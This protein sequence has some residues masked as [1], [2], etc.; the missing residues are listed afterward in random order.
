MIVGLLL[1]FLLGL[2]FGSFF[3]L[4]ADRSITNESIVKGH[5]HCDF[6][7]TELRPK[8]LIPVF[9]YVLSGGKCRYCSHQLSFWYPLSE[10]VTG[11][12]FS[13]AYIWFVLEGK[14]IIF[15]FVIFSF[16]AILFITDAKYQ[17]IPDQ[18]VYKAIAFAFIWL[19]AETFMRNYQ[20]MQT[21]GLTLDI[22]AL[23]GK[24]LAV[25]TYPLVSAA[26]IALFFWFLVWITK[27]RGMGGGDITLGLLLGL[28]TGF[29]YNVLA[30][31]LAMIFGALYSIPL[32]LVRKKGMKDAVAFGPFLIIGSIT[33]IFFGS[34]LITAYIA[35]LL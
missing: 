15:A 13:V 35:H 3:K 31:F 10:L 24:S 2:F 14:S 20:V 1:F 22:V 25:L 12:L 27:E 29:P 34:Q 21:S 11:V 9:S 19:V 17:L 26:G 4:I 8:D 7:K 30:V 16:Y 32:L 18:V 23:V 28:V 33:A 5:S 6:C